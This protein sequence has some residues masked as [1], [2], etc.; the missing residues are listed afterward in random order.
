MSTAT[1]S[2][3]AFEG[4]APEFRWLDPKLLVTNPA[5]AR[6]ELRD[7]DELA[8]SI[9]ESGIVEPLVVVPD[10][11]GTHR[12]LA[13]HRRAA[14][15]VIA[16]LELVP[17]WLRP[18]LADD[19]EQQLAAALVENIQRED[20]TEVE[21][22][23]AYAQLAAFPA[24]SIERVAKAAGRSSDEVRRAVDATQLPEHLQQPAITGGL[25]L[26]QAKRLESFAEDPGTYRRLL[27]HAGERGFAHLLSREER[28]R[29]IARRLDESRQALDAAGVRIIDRPGYRSLP[30]RLT[31]L[32]DGEGT[33]FDSDDNSHLSCPGHAAYLDAYT[34]EAVYVCQEP[35]AY[36]HSTPPWYRHLTP[37]E[38]EA[39][40][41]EEE[42]AQVR[43]AEL[44]VA[45][46]VRRNFVRERI[47]AKGKPAAGTLRVAVETLLD[48]ELTTDIENY[49]ADIAWFLGHDEPEEIDVDEAIRTALRKSNDTRLVHVLLAAGAAI[50]ERNVRAYE[51][52][53]S[54]SPA[55]T[56][57]WFTFLTALGYETTEA[58]NALCAAARESVADVAAA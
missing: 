56:L 21:E 22:A 7:L 52:A 8:A 31:D 53:W 51:I 55:N 42:A 39:Q 58:E 37:E 6:S 57:R 50:A 27:R 25:S 15:A 5:N 1:S 24:W 46:G 14:A 47:A 2:Q 35:L 11:D 44:E 26:D 16:G 23:H 43:A 30:V 3:P 36:G 18:D 10:G 54:Y 41:A 4:E 28:N 12:I 48:P 20:L 19:A 29:E 17:C 9:A 33:P 34:G 45:A 32:F 49:S 40:A 38:A 13:G